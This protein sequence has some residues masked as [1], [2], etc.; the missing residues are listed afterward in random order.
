VVV[1]VTDGTCD[2]G[3]AATCGAD[4][5]T[6]GAGGFAVVVGDTVVG[7][8]VVGETGATGGAGG[9][10]A[11]CVCG[12]DSMLGGAGGGA[13]AFGGTSADGA[14]VSSVTCTFGSGAATVV[15]ATGVVSEGSVPGF[16]N[17]GAIPPVSAVREI[18]NP[19]ARTATTLRLEQIS[20]GA[21][22]CID[23]SCLTEQ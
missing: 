7:D 4:D 23:S 22:M 14:A 16:A 11:C 18:T 20:S 3:G 12:G 5:S 10:S 8:T 1:E 15:V 17:A 13:G 2:V 19:D 6:T 9:A 21:P